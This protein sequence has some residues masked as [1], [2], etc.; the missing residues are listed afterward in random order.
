MKEQDNYLPGF[1]TPDVFGLCNH[2]YL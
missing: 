1:F 2:N